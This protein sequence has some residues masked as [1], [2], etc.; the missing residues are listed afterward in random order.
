M[1]SYIDRTHDAVNRVY[2]NS[3]MA[4]HR[5]LANTIHC[6]ETAADIVQEIYLRLPQLQPVPDSDAAVK[7]WLFRV[8]TNMALDGFRMEKRRS[9]L[10]QHY[11][12]HFDDSDSVP[13]PENL[14]MEEKQLQ[15][16]QNAIKALPPR[17]KDVLYLSR[18][19]G[20]TQD[21]VAERLS[22]S[23]SWVEKLLVKALT[24]LRQA[25]EEK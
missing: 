19:E 24:H 13:S 1:M 21:A 23:R 8:A 6:P 10:L 18:I 17:Y 5:Y 16:L 9:E 3:H 15:N 12:A 22:I 20:L 11:L 4:L 7:S 2:L 14:A 25:L